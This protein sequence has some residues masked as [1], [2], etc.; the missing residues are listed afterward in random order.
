MAGRL[1]GVSRLAALGVTALA[2]V[3]AAAAS[4]APARYATDF[5][6][7]WITATPGGL[8]VSQDHV[9]ATL[10]T[11][12]LHNVGAYPARFQIAAPGSKLVDVTLKP[13]AWR[14]PRVTFKPATTYSIKVTTG[15]GS[16]AYAASLPSQ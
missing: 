1:R 14:F 16:A 6:V 3:P 8:Y 4:A 10:Y 13:N 11:L 9:G 15:P 5:K 2:L 7:L 12:D